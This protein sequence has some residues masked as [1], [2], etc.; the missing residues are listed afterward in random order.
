M[1]KRWF[2]YFLFLCLSLVIVSVPV[3]ADTK[4]KKNPTVIK[5]S[6]A[7]RVVT[8][9]YSSTHY[10]VGTRKVPTGTQ[11]GTITERYYV[12]AVRPCDNCKN[13]VY[14]ANRSNGKIIKVFSEYWGHMN[15]FHYKW[16]SNHVYINSSN[17]GNA[18][19][20]KSK[21]PNSSCIDVS[22]LKKLGNNYSACKTKSAVNWNVMDGLTAQ[23]EAE[24]GGNVWVVAWNSSTNDNYIG[25]YKRSN[26]SFVKS[27]KIP[28]SVTRG[29]AED[30]A[31]DGSTGDV[32]VNYNLRDGSGRIGY[33]RIDHSVFGDLTKPKTDN[34]K[35]DSKKDDSKKDGNKKED[36]KKDND[37]SNGT[38]SSDGPT[39]SDS[40]QSG[41]KIAPER[42]AQCAS[43]L[44][45][46][47]NDAGSDGEQTI[48]NII[49][50]II[51]AM[52]IG[53]TTLG[54][55]GLIYSGYLIMTAR[56][57]ASQ[58]AKGKKRIVEIIIGI[59]IWVLAASIMTL[60]LPND[61]GD[62]TKDL[63][64]TDSSATS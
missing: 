62:V 13:Y 59:V 21:I 48:R 63:G 47:C 15:S 31:I 33:T 10:G 28:A 3:H 7:K 1:I 39:D 54:T 30:I 44:S 9:K 2:C 6:Q 64:K 17:K 32:Y 26:K 46:W 53:V 40:G 5:S 23:G 60:L 42:E 45:F 57:D 4:W 41:V 20:N 56:D 51:S 52:T 18:S 61:D 22:S 34:K 11:G 50:F 14:V 29:E 8:Y 24:Y 25:V 38:P 35:E 55:I 58:V 27:Y 43:I 49:S 19:S 16:G 36:S 37:K 12:F